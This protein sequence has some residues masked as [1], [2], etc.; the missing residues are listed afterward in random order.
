[1]PGKVNPSV[2]EMVNQVCLPGDRLRRDGVRRGRGRAARAE[3]DDAGDRLERAALVDDPAQRDERAADPHASTASR[4]TRSA[5]ASCS[6]A[7]PPW[8]RRSART[9]ATPRP[10]RSPRRRCARDDPIRELVLERGLMDAQQLDRD[11]LGRGDDA[12]RHR[13]ERHVMKTRRYAVVAAI[14]RARRTRRGGS[15]DPPDGPSDAGAAAAPRRAVSADD[16]GLLERPD[17]ARGRSPTRSWTR[18]NRRRID[19]RRHRRRRRVVHDPARAA[20]RAERARL[21]AGRAAADA[22]RDQAARAARGAGE[23]RDA[24]GARQRS[25]SPGQGARRG[26]DGRCVSGSREIASPTFATSRAR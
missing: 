10:P 2:P 15:S 1:M 4:P 20:R 11:P 9:S 6:I 16:L 3:R 7:A 5:A 18:V 12:A 23:R 24:A 14:A 8:R 26:P 17:R 25:Q 21:R 13:R 19:G 22:R